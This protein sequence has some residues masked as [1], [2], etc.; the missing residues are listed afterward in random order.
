MRSGTKFCKWTALI[1]GAAL[2]LFSFTGSVVHACSTVALSM[3]D[4]P[5]VAYNFDYE[6]TGVGMLLVNPG[7]GTRRSVLEGEAAQWPIRYGSVTINQVGPGMPV[8]GMNTAGLVVT[9]MWNADAVFPVRGEG[10]LVTELEFVQFLLD[11]SAMVSDALAAL[12][13]IRISGRVPIHY[14]LADRFGNTASVTPTKDGLIIHQ[15]D[16]M[17][18]AALTNT[19]YG[20]ALAHITDQGPMETGSMPEGAGSLQRF[21]RAAAAQRGMPLLDP[22]EGFA[23]LDDIRHPSTRWQL[24]FDPADLLIL[25]KVDG[26]GVP[27]KAALN[28]LDFGCRANPHSADLNALPLQDLERSLQPLAHGPLADTVAEVFATMR[29]TAPMARPEI[30]S[31]I[32]HGLLQTVSCNP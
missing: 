16:Q 21:M 7:E 10:A 17:P 32:A 31:A 25:L 15:G 11:G 26:A 18:V 23:V 29:A 22:E 2:I 1:Q 30:A 12:D 27:R 5:L 20:D 14:F 4:R 24:V 8:A 13:E 28:E 3:P 9:M 19:S 6:P